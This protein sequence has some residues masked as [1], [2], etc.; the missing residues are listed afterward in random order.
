V[1]RDSG[2]AERDESRATL[3][4]RRH[5]L[6]A[7][8]SWSRAKVQMDPVLRGLALRNA[9]KEDPRTGPS[10]VDQRRG[11]VAAFGRN[12]HRGECGV[13]RIEPARRSLDPIVENLRPEASERSRIVTVETH[14]ELASHGCHP[15]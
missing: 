9:L 2:R 10:W 1:A 5:P 15:F 14:L 12:S 6:G 7:G 13:P 4:Q 8:Q 11:V 3:L